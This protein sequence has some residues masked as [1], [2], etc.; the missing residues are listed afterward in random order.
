MQVLVIG[1]T[2]FIGPHVVRRLVEAGHD[3]TVFHRGQTEAELPED[4]REMHGDRQNLRDFAAEFKRLAPDVVLDMILF[5]EDNARALMEIFK[6]VAGRVVAPSSM[7]VYRAYGRLL[8]LETGTPDPVPYTEDGPLRETLFPYR[9]RAKGPDDE[10]PLKYEKIL[11]ERI[12][13]NDAELPG[14]ILR[15]PAVYGPKDKNHRLFQYL[16]HMDDGRPAIVLEETQARWL[17]TRGYVENVADALALAV[18]DERSTA[19]LYNVGEAETLTEADWVRSIARVAGW[20]GEV[21]V[22]PKSALPEELVEDHPYEHHLASDSSRIR[23]ELGYT[24]RINL[25][26]ALRRTIDWER[27][28]PPA[29]INE[30]DFNYAA[31]DKALAMLKKRT[32]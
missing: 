19:R 6:G 30:K 22:L 32:A 25:D 4:V 26:E 3:V 14:T 10:F 9:E 28:N 31:E 17:W 18:M 7:D 13:M 5:R 16:K 11:A 2:S 23:E 1:G 15:L 12:V 29:E 21:V 20:T 8:K 24:E 27:A